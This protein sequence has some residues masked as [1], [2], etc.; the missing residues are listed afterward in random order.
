M[1]NIFDDVVA[2]AQQMFEGQD[3][4]TCVSGMKLYWNN[5]LVT[6]QIA[7]GSL[8]NEKYFQYIIDRVCADLPSQESNFKI[9]WGWMD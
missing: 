8:T 2:E 5:L 4:G 7:Q 1:I 9:D 3:Q 6:T